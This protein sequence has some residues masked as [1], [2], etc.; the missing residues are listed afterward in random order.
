MDNVTNCFDNR[1]SCRSALNNIIPSSTGASNN[2]S[3]ILTTMKGKIN[4]FAVRVPT[5]NV[6]LVDMNVSLNRKLD[7][8]HS[9]ELKSDI[10]SLEEV[11]E[12]FE[13]YR[14]YIN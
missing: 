14:S 6:S 3:K 13:C 2:I 5:T 1:S 11:F 8:I 12:C 9:E 4:G 7:P 10:I